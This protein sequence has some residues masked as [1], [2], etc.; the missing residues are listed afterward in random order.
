MTLLF[1]LAIP[2]NAQAKLKARVA[3]GE[4]IRPEELKSSYAQAVNQGGQLPSRRKYRYISLKAAGDFA[5]VGAQSRGAIA[6][7]N[8]CHS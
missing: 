3:R 1:S 4:V 8:G 5:E 2:Q 6:Q 7:G